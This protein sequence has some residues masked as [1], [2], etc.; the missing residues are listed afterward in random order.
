MTEYSLL[1]DLIVSSAPSRQSKIEICEKAFAQTNEWLRTLKLENQQCQSSLLLSSA[2]SASVEVVS[3]AYLGLMR[4]S[5]GSLRIYYELS[6]AW[7]YYKDHPVEWG[8]IEYGKAQVLLPGAIHKYLKEYIVDYD[9]KWKALSEHKTRSY[10]DPYKIM[11]GFVHG[12]LLATLP[13]TV[14]PKDILFDD[15]V[16]EQLPSFIKCVCEYIEDVYVCAHL[17]NWESLPG[18]IRNTLESRLGGKAKTALQFC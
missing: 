9:K 2:L 18:A 1:L 4:Q 15:A 6:L 12:G 13:S 7:L 17:A 3:T 8:Q 5:I 16:I 14:M 11:S 10:D